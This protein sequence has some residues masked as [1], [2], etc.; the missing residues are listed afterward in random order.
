MKKIA[1][2][3]SIIG[4]SCFSMPILAQQQ[5]YILL[6][7]LDSLYQ[8]NRYTLNAEELYGVDETIELYNIHDGGLILF[9]VLPDFE[10]DQNWTEVQLE[11]IRHQLLDE[12]AF[13]S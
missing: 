5:Q 1:T 13:R 7:M 11:S 4:F 12:R 9:S 6:T 8:I 2:Y 10:S 3:L